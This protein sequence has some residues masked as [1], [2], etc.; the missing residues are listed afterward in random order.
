M[1]A[2][3]VNVV[4]GDEFRGAGC[5]LNSEREQKL[6]GIAR[7]DLLKKSLMDHDLHRPRK[8]DWNLDEHYH[9][10]RTDNN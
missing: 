8:D 5:P 4:F 6:K 2:G 7:R 9:V 10:V 3:I 1:D